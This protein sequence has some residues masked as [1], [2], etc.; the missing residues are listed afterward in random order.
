[1][2]STN[3]QSN[4]Q[5]PASEIDEIVAR[6]LQDLGANPMPN[7]TA[8]TI[9]NTAVNTIEV[10]TDISSTD[11]DYNEVT[12]DAETLA[13]QVTDSITRQV[14]QV[15]EEHNEDTS[16]NIQ[17]NSG[18]TNV[19]EITSRFSGAIWFEKI[20]EM[21]ITVAGIGGI[22]SYVAFLLSRLDPR[23][24]DV[25]DQDIVE[26]GN[27]SGQLF[28]LEDVGDSKVNSAYRMA[29]RFSNYHKMNSVRTRVGE[30]FAGRDI[31]IC[32]FDNMEARKVYY[33]S[34]KEHVAQIRK[35]DKSN[36]LFID[37]RLAAEE[38]QVFCIT[39][40]D[41]KSMARYE[42]KF[43]FDD[44]EAAE[45]ICSYKQTTF[46]A[47]MI[48]SV[49]VNLFVNFVSNMCNPI[50]PRD[51]PFMTTYNGETMYFKVVS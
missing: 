16:G 21:N 11:E 51:L 30:D 8:Q 17:E 44:S 15:V 4:N 39:G 48:G 2:N 49:I 38:F 18:S 14:E 41:T 50:I 5:I 26:A 27:L 29:S 43:L 7:E 45:T 22:G 47:T 42:R 28:S 10:P 9:V 20:K 3:E 1:M 36:C 34:W 40:D 25:I 12:E 13:Q 35:E 31:M 19:S 24:I 46:M 23:R 37:G 33:Q 6:A 32:G